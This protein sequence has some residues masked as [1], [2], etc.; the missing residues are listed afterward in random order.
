WANPHS[1]WTT[2]RGPLI[3]SSSY[4]TSLCSDPLDG[5]SN[6]RWKIRVRRSIRSHKIGDSATRP[7]GFLLIVPEVALTCAS[8]PGSLAGGAAPGTGPDV[9]LGAV[10]GSGRRGVGAGPAGCRDAPVS[11]GV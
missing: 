3:R 7:P 6:S 10:P 8:E 5:S 4:S 2:H 11:P 9:C 1:P